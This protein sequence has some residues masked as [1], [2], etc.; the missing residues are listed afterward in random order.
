MSID[1]GEHVLFAHDEEV[2]AGAAFFVLVA[3]PGGEQDRFP[4]L[5]LQAAAAAVFQQLAGADG[6]DFAPLRFVLG[7][8]RQ[9]DAARRLLRRLLAADDDPVADGLNFHR[10][11]SK[12]V[13]YRQWD[14]GTL[15]SCVPVTPGWRNC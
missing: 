12:S 14:T 4:L 11:L 1:D 5:H 9:H 8:V 10:T 2:V 13:R 15:A 7:R 3:G 6:K